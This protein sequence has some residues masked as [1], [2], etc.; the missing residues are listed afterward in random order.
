MTVRSIVKP[1]I[2]TITKVKSIRLPLRFLSRSGLLPYYI[3]S[4]LTYEGI[5]VVR[6]E[7]GKSFK[8]S[9][10]K[11]DVIGRI[12]YWRALKS[13]ES[14]T[15]PVF[16]S[17]AKKAR[18]VIDIGANCGI[19]TLLACAANS[20][21]RII[22]FEPAPT[23]CSQLSKN[24]GINNWECRCDVR[25]EAV[26]DY[27]GYSK[28]HIPF[29]DTYTSCSSLNPEGHRGIDGYLIEVPIIRIDSLDLGDQK[30]DLIKLDIE[31]FEDKALKGMEMTLQRSCPDIIIECLYDGPYERVNNILA[32]LGYSFFH[33]VPTGPKQIDKIVTAKDDCCANYLCTIDRFLRKLN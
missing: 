8:Y 30:V 27:D 25:S 14:E 9:T 10:S 3:Y 16:Y 20:E 24:I 26:S 15:I 12:L 17:L 33:L 28:F 32:G 2:E 19:Y 7:D 22:C 23:T 31:N 6:L 21:S 11:D 5:F 13:W 1:Y 18:L 29:S 4:R